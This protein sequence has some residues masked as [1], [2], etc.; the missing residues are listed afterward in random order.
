[1]DELCEAT[2]EEILAFPNPPPP[3]RRPGRPRKEPALLEDREP[4]PTFDP[5]AVL[6]FPKA[7]LRKQ[8]RGRPR[9][10][11]AELTATPERDAEILK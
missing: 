3:K 5:A 11:S 6:P 9:R 2:V 4:P 10:H 8:T 1:M 7:A